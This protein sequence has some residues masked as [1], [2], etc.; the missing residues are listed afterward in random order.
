MQVASLSS[1]QALPPSA[2]GAAR[3]VSSADSRP[4]ATELT[5]TPES[6]APADAVGQRAGVVASERR[7]QQAEQQSEQQEI[8]RLSLRDQEVRA[9]EQAH[10]AVGGHHAGAPRYSYTYGPD[11]KRYATEGEVS[12]DTA[13]VSGDPAATLRK[14]TKVLA[15]ALAPAEPSAQDRQ[16]AAQAQMA[17]GQA[18]LEL[19][20]L[21][22]EQAPA[23]RAAVSKQAD[24]AS[25]QPGSARNEL[26]A[27]QNFLGAAQPGAAIDVQA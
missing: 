4:T 18:Q 21:Q 26:S 16:V 23:S 7:L 2:Q 19:L 13:Q 17:L 25:A 20:Q 1:Y 5:P 3:A 8:S 24:S 12:I 22:R 11:G 14:M 6:A 15:A 9:H 27:Y 10:A